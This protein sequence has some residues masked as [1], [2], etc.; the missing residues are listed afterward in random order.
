MTKIKSGVFKESKWI[1]H[2]NKR[3]VK[4]FPSVKVHQEKSPMTDGQIGRNGEEFGLT[5]RNL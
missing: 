3:K 1:V 2:I 4:S 5:I